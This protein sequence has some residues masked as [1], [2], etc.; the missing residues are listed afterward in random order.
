MVIG[1]LVTDYRPIL[2][3]TNKNAAQFADAKFSEHG[4]MV[5]EEGLKLAVQIG[6]GYSGG[7]EHIVPIAAGGKVI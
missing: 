5:G 3:A 2:L 1:L 7:Q 4:K 6:P